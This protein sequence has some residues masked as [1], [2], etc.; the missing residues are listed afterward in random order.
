[1]KNSLLLILATS[2]ALSASSQT[3]KE[4]KF[5]KFNGVTTATTTTEPLVQSMGIPQ[6]SIFGS[7]SSKDGESQIALFFTYYPGRTSSLKKGESEFV[8]LEDGKDPITLKY[9]GDYKIITTT[10]KAVFFSIVTPEQLKLL[11]DRKVTD[12]RTTGYDYKVKEKQQ[13]TIS[14]I[15]KLLLAQPAAGAGR[16]TSSQSDGTTSLADELK[17]LKGLLD[18]GAI[19][20]EEYDTAKKKLLAQ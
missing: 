13:G 20:Q 3:I 6:V 5:D 17:K 10:D 4:T 8:L 7:V 11:V 9:S 16:D 19:T 12:I 18:S 14:N 15:A 2:L 1:M